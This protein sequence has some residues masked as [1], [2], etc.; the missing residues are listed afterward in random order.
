MV[1]GEQSAVDNRN[2]KGTAFTPDKQA[3]NKMPD[4]CAWMRWEIASPP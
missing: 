4:N 3:N 2:F 1:Y